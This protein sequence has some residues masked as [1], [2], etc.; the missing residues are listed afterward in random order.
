[1]ISYC[2]SC[3]Q[4]TFKD[5]FIIFFGCIG[6]PL[7]CMAFL[8]FVASGGLPFTVTAA[9][10]LRWLLLLEHRLWM[11]RDQKLQLAFSREVD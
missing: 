7:L 4:S 5:L 10:S 3:M 2:L 6:S 1:M 9:F 8:W 11:D